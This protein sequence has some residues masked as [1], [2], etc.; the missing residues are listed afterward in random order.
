MVSGGTLDLNTREHLKLNRRQQRK[1]R[2]TD[3]T[4]KLL[5]HSSELVK[6]WGQAPRGSPISRTLVQPARS[7]SPLL[8]KLSPLLQATRTK[9]DA[10]HTNP[11]R[12]RG[13][14]CRPSLALRVGVVGGPGVPFPASCFSLLLSQSLSSLCYLSFLLFKA[15]ALS[16]RVAEKMET[17]M[18]Q[19]LT[20]TIIEIS[21]ERKKPLRRLDLASVWPLRRPLAGPCRANQRKNASPR[22]TTTCDRPS[23]FFHGQRMPGKKPHGRD[24]A[25]SIAASCPP[26][27]PWVGWARRA[28]CGTIR[29]P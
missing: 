16:T 4:D 23:G 10:N 8:H 21:P 6:K 14:P 5:G 25:E 20:A 22:W 28:Q 1:R 12:Q 13:N 29:L 18:V 2:R 19:G 3:M 9:R 15:L 26:Q 17:I 24:A 11:T 27:R 7:Q